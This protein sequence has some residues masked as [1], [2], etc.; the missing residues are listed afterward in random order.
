MSEIIRAAISRELNSR[1]AGS[2]VDIPSLVQDYGPGVKEVL[3]QLRYEDA[4]H[5]ITIST[6]LASW[7]AENGYTDDQVIRGECEVFGQVV[8]A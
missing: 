6:D 7:L 5:L 8:K 2:V 3:W 4:V 1:P